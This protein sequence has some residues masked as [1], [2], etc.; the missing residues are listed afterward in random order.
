MIHKAALLLA[1]VLLGP[2][3]F[4]PPSKVPKFWTTNLEKNTNHL[5]QQITILFIGQ[6]RIGILDWTTPLVEHLD[7]PWLV[8]AITRIWLA[9]VN[10]SL[11]PINREN[12]QN[13]TAAA[14]SGLSQN[15]HLCPCLPF[16]VPMCIGSW[17]I[18][19]K[20]LKKL[21]L[22]WNFCAA[23][24]YSSFW[25][26]SVSLCVCLPVCIHAK[27]SRKTSLSLI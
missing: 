10:R 19:C 27:T 23:C 9:A 17:Q 25:R 8:I 5:F 21:F 3:Y 24:V 15:Q 20:H 12:S 1:A 22:R 2:F 11:Y 18:K 13:P 4:S 16:P 14:P 26:A 7:Q 6:G